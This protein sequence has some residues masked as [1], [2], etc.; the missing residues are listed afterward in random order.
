VTD[1]VVEHFEGLGRSGSWSD[2][3]D[4]PET[5]ANT[6]FRSRLERTVE[7]LP[8]DCRSVLDAGCGPAPLAAAIAGRGIRYLGLDV[9][10][11]MLDQARSRVQGV[12]LVRG[13][14]PLPIRDETFDAVVALGFLEYFED[15]VA[16]L[17][18]LS[19]VAKKGGVILVSTPKKHHLS[20]TMVRLTAPFR[21]VAGMLVGR[22]SDSI[23]RTL[24]DPDELDQEAVKAGLAPEGG[25][26]YHFTVL[27][28]PITVLAPGVALRFNRRFETATRAAPLAYSA[29]GYVGR[30]RRG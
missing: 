8:P 4:G 22:R 7:L 17:R 3:Y 12:T 15:P 10:G 28:Y 18:E 9:S 23:R 27:P 11:G 24:L 26:H 14:V 25:S 13:A 6:S 21:A 19:R 30:Y 5:S 16:V 2:L 1:E 29:Q 20:R